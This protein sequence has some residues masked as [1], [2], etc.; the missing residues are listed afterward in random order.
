MV[1]LL[2]LLFTYCVDDSVLAWA[3][4]D[5]C[6]AFVGL[7]DRSFREYVS[8]YE[9]SV[10]RVFDYAFDLCYDCLFPFD[11]IDLVGLDDTSLCAA[12]FC[13]VRSH[14]GLVFDLRHAR[15]SS[16]SA[17]PF[18]IRACVSSAARLS[19]ASCMHYNHVA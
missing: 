6:L 17:L 3:V 7:D 18:R 1:V 12:A 5:S 9:V 19:F 8:P 14:S 11:E 10:R 15:I 2:P 16:D 4:R 13:P